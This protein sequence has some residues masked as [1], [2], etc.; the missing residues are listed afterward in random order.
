MPVRSAFP[1]S[2]I[3]DLRSR[4]SGFTL[5]ELVAA[6]VIFALAFGVLLQILGTALKT[7]AQSAEYTRAAMW[8]QS[9]LDVQGIGEPIQEGS[10]S[11]RFD[12]NYRW[13]LNIARYEPPPV[14]TTVAPLTTADAGGLITTPVTPLD[15]FHL[16]LIVS[17]GP[18]YLVHHARFTT[19]RAMNPPLQAGNT[20]PP[21]APIRSRQ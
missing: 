12:D 16:E 5:V 11:G 6:F 13:Q 20:I 7:T 8:A 18:S 1:R 19:V 2:P 9:L 15:L 17:W 3:S 4:Q 10:S 21:P 14:Q